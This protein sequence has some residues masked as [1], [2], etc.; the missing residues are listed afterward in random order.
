MESLP[1]AEQERIRV[2]VDRLVPHISLDAPKGATFE[3]EG[4][5]GMLFA[6]VSCDGDEYEQLIEVGVHDSQR[7][8]ALEAARSVP[9]PPPPRTLTRE[10]AIAIVKAGI[11]KGEG[12]PSGAEY[13]DSVRHIWKG[14]AH[15]G[16]RAS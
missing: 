7:D 2:S 10:E 15:G 14:L 9:K 1:D 11:G 8:R 12:S 6:E 16:E 13:V 3:V 4:S 5:D